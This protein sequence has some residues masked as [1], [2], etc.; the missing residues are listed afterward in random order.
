MRTSE[1]G[2]LTSPGFADGQFYRTNLLCEWILLGDPG[3]VFKISF[4]SFMLEQ[5][6]TCE[7]DYFTVSDVVVFEE[8]LSD[9]FTNVTALNTTSEDIKRDNAASIAKPTLYESRR[10]NET[11][12]LLTA[13]GYHL[14]YDVET[15]SHMVLLAFH[16]DEQVG[17]RGFNLTFSRVKPTCKG[18][19]S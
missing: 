1:S 14:P 11:E 17:G 18:I 3:E 9:G 12:I 8:P 16:S 10:L 2:Q 15:K 6:P 13:C 5:S 19:Y 4:S 7:Y